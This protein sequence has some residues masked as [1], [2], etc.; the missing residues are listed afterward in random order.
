MLERHLDTRADAVLVDVVHREA[1]D[2]VFPE[3]TFFR[4][5]DIAQADIDAAERERGKTKSWNGTIEERGE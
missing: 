4:R 3:D 1:F 5:V 2:V